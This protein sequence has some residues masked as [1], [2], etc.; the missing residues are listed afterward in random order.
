MVYRKHPSKS[1][2]YKKVQTQEHNTH[3]QEPLLLAEHN[4]SSEPRASDDRKK[5]QPF[6]FLSSLFG[7]EK[8][9]RSGKPLFNILDYDIYLDDLLLAGLIILLLT[10][11]VQD[12]LL[13]IVLVYLLVD[14]F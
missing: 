3:N 5:S 14:I 8:T 9:E 7:G 13:L 10:D 6:G 12:E 4:V 2:R 1:R 11:K